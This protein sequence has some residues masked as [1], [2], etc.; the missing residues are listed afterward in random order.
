MRVVIGRLRRAPSCRASRRRGRLAA[1]A[2]RFGCRRSAGSGCRRRERRPAGGR[3]EVRTHPVLAVG[4]LVGPGLA[5]TRGFI[6]DRREVVLPVLDDRRQVLHAEFRGLL[7]T[8]P[9]GGLDGPAEEPDRVG[10]VVDRQ[11]PGQRAVGRLVDVEEV[12]ERGRRDVQR[13]LDV[14]EAVDQRLLTD[15]SL[16]GRGAERLAVVVGEAL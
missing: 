10:E 13:L 15:A 4:H 2:R 12:L 1:A 9:G 3:N 7:G 5:P 11:R 14:V 8:Q 6:A 16:S